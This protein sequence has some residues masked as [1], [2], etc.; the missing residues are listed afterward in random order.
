V[1]YSVDGRSATALTL[2]SGVWPGGTVVGLTGE[3]DLATAGHLPRFVGALAPED[4]RWVHLDLAGLDFI[5]A[6]GLTA[7]LRA[8][9]VVEERSGRMTVGRPRPL[10]RLVM[11][12]TA[13]PV[14]VVDHAMDP[15]AEQPA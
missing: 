12:L 5:D 2:T 1:T 14:T 10:A 8:G 13:L 4:C 11:E 6:A 15:A 3:L 9:A 7:L